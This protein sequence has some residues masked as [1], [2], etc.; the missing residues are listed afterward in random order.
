MTRIF[1]GDEQGSVMVETA[2]SFFLIITCVLG[3]IECCLMVYTYAVYADAARHGVRYATFHGT[4]STSCSGPSAG[5]D[6][7][8]ASVVSDVTTYAS[9]YAAPASGL[10]VTVTYPDAGGSKASSRVIVN[11]A[12]SYH[13]LFNFPGTPTNFQVKSQGRIVY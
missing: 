5:C 10:T 4:D 3:I 8:A 1:H 12:Y 13:P 7:T 2:L 9:G 6:S 11:V